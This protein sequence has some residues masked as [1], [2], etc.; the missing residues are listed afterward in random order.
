MLNNSINGPAILPVHHRHS[1]SGYPP[2][3]P[4]SDSG[5][6]ASIAAHSTVLAAASVPPNAGN[7]LN[8]TG[9]VASSTTS[10]DDKIKIS[11]LLS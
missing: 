8:P 5:P 10:G 6:L 11:N 1:V 3:Q 9:G 2:D 7:S 4:M